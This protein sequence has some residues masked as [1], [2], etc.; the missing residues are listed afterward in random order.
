MSSVLVNGARL[1]AADVCN[2]NHRNVCLE[3]INKTTFLN[4]MI[5]I[6]FRSLWY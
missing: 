6:M 2:V 3:I 5:S 1:V 4:T